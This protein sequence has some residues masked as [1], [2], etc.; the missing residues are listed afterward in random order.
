MLI[1]VD[2][3]DFLETSNNIICSAALLCLRG[4]RAEFA[5]VDQGDTE[6][7]VGLHVLMPN[8]VY[9]F[10]FVSRSKNERGAHLG[11]RRK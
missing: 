8:S 9:G 3:P 7:R 1:E 10:I 6:S 2:E 4:C 11:Q 5:E